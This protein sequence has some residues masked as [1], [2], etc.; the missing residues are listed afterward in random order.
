MFW[1]RS[2]KYDIEP[3]ETGTTPLPIIGNT[4]VSETMIPRRYVNSQGESLYDTPGFMASFGPL[5]EVYDSYAN[6][7]IFKKNG[8][9]KIILVID[10]PTLDSSRGQFLSEAVERLSKMFPEETKSVFDSTCIVVTKANTNSVVNENM[11][12]R[13]NKIMNEQMRTNEDRFVY[14]NYILEIANAGRIFCFP[15]P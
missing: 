6:S 11:K 5:Q 1:F 14:F 2:E 9:I 4:S 12:L 3:Q 13:I 8:Q 15:N 10:K 7:K